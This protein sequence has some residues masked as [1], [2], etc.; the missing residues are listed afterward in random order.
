MRLRIKIKFETELGCLNAHT[1][2]YQLNSR[3]INIIGSNVRVPPTP[4]PRPTGTWL[5]YTAHPMK[6]VGH[7]GL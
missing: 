2:P 7:G 1:T 6:S 4:T 3:I 5:S